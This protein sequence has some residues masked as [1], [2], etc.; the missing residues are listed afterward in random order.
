MSCKASKSS[1]HCSYQCGI[2]QSTRDVPLSASAI[3]L[4]RSDGNGISA[5]TDLYGDYYVSSFIIGAESAVLLHT[6]SLD[7]QNTEDVKLVAEIEFFCFSDTETIAEKTFI[8]QHS[9]ARFGVTAF[10]TLENQFV[11]IGNEGTLGPG[12]TIDQARSL[13]KLYADRVEALPR[14]VLEPLERLAS[15]L[16]PKSTRQAFDRTT[17]ETV[18]SSGLVLQVLLMPFARMREVMEILAQVT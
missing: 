9:D 5:F 7:V 14:R 13:A 3:A 18:M 17:L 1:R 2:I 8:E 15:V 12:L 11:D 16:D 6:S 10:D 4:L